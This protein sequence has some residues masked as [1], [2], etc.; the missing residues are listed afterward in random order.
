MEHRLA[1]PGLEPVANLRVTR[2]DTA[3]L[4]P[5]TNLD[6]DNRQ[7]FYSPDLPLELPVRPP[8]AVSTPYQT[9]TPPRERICGLPKTSFWVA[10]VLVLLVLGGAIGGGIAG[11]IAANNSSSR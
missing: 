6:R 2:N 9:T 7:Q 11:G 10:F 8:V 4:E 3:G 1:S 5:V